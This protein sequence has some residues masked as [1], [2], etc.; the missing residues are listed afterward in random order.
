MIF[1]SWNWRTMTWHSLKPFWKLDWANRR[2]GVLPARLQHRNVKRSI[3]QLSQQCRKKSTAHGTLQECWLRK[4]FKW[5]IH[6][7]IQW[8]KNYRKSQDTRC[9]RNSPGTS[10]QLP[11]GL[12]VNKTIKRHKSTKHG[13]IQIEHNLKLTT[14]VLRILVLSMWMNIKRV[15][16]MILESKRTY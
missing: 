2:Y 6:W 13:G 9:L 1:S 10:W 15:N 16:L 3:G 12:S 8:T 14:I 5:T 7:K 4:H 11:T